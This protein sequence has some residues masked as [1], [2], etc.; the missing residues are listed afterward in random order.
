MS[1]SDIKTHFSLNNIYF[2]AKLKREKNVM[3]KVEIHKY[4]KFQA[5]NFKKKF[6]KILTLILIKISN[7]NSNNEDLDIEL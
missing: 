7:K 4:S 6:K 3:Q 1:K 5:F 2:I